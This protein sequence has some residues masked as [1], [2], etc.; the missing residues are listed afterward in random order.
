MNFSY[1]LQKYCIFTKNFMIFDRFGEKSWNFCEIFWSFRGFCGKQIQNYTG[2]ACRLSLWSKKGIGISLLWLIFPAGACEN[3]KFW[4]KSGL[5]ELKIGKMAPR[6]K[7]WFFLIFCL[8]RCTKRKIYD[9]LAC[10]DSF[11]MKNHDFWIFVVAK[12]V[13]IIYF[14]WFFFL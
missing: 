5:G 11:L 2:P 7:S 13:K 6:Q 10:P 9:F 1:F 3:A 8:Y 14:H 4:S 12:N